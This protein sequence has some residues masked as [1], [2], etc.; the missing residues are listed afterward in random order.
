MRMPIIISLFTVLK[1]RENFAP[2]SFY[3]FALQCNLIFPF[4]VNWLI[5]VFSHVNLIGRDGQLYTSIYDKR[6][7][8]NFHITNCPFLSSNF[9]S[10]PAYGIFR[11]QPI[12]YAQAFSSYEYFILK[13]RQLSNKLL[14]QGYIM[15]CLKLSFKIYGWYLFNS[16]KCPSLAMLD[17]ILKS[18]HFSATSHLIRLY[19]WLDFTPILLPW[20]R[21]LPNYERIPRSICNG[22][23][24]QAGKAYPCIHLVLSLFGTCICFNCWDQFFHTCS[25]FLDFPF[26]IFLSTFSILLLNDFILSVPLYCYRHCWSTFSR[27]CYNWPMLRSNSHKGYMIKILFTIPYECAWNVTCME[28]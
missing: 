18:D 12:W 19:I 15:G 13:A 22:C 8:F 2:V 6:D 9:P 27:S 16:M 23:G 3:I 20:Y 26:W 25:D 21:T 5:M 7:N 1:Y 11:L 4:I 17:A 10:L 14:K 24:M 28:L